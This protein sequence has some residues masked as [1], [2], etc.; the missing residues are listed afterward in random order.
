MTL[1][2]IAIIIIAFLLFDILFYL[3]VVK[4]MM[5]KSIV[6]AD[7]PSRK[8]R[9]KN[10]PHFNVQL[11]YKPVI[12]TAVSAFSQAAGA[13]IHTSQELYI[14]QE[15]D[16]LTLEKIDFLPPYDL[17]VGVPAKITAVL[18]QDFSRGITQKEN[19]QSAHNVR[20]FPVGTYVKA[21][22]KS[23]VLNIK[24]LTSEEKLLKEEFGQ[25]EWE[26]VPIKSGKRVLALD[27]EIRIKTPNHEYQKQFAYP[28][29]EVKIFAN[30]FFILPASVRKYFL[31][32]AIA[33]LLIGSIILLALSWNKS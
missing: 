4:G 9:D 26:V 31:W 5:V 19:E 22:I 15:M 3:Y 30:A 11:L 29:G 28:G 14:K 18:T 24:S 10:V 7:D 27:I 17:M 12:G 25:W 8:P 33:T 32:T 13:E 21:R 20:A 16:N 6:G 2:S 1:S 23:D